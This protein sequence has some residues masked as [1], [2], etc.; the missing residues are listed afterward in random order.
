MIKIGLTGG[1]GSGKTTLAKM[2]EQK[3]IPVYYAD[4]RAKELMQTDSKLITRIKQLLGEKAYQN[5]RLNTKYISEIV[6][7][8]PEKLTALE[9]IVHPAVLQDF[10]SWAKRQKSAFVI[11]ENAILHKSGMDKEMD[12]VILV[13]ANDEIRQQRVVKRDKTSPEAVKKRMQ[14]QEK[15]TELLKKSDFV[16]ENNFS[17][18]NLRQK[19]ERIFENVNFKLKKR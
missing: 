2:F 14:N 5:N 6:F 1:I 9:Q 3:G 18:E 19:I 8:K 10:L 16:I 13:T 12:Y 11:M 7:E 17:M 15:Q 4:N